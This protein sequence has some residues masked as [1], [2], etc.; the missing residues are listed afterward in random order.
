M[1]ELYEK[2]NV[3]FGVGEDGH[4]LFMET[5]NIGIHITA[6]CDSNP[7]YQGMYLMNKP[8]LSMDE[9]CG[10]YQD[11]NLLIGSRKYFDE[12][13]RQLSDCGFDRL[14]SW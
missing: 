14:Y 11:C 6:F 10:A 13:S 8:V 5:L 4:R 3:I 12:I 7:A 1:P 9:L 2:E